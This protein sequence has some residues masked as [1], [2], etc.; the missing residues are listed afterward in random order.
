MQPNVSVQPVATKLDS[1]GTLF[2]PFGQALRTYC[3]GS[4]L[5]LVIVSVRHDGSVMRTEV[6]AQALQASAERVETVA[7]SMF[8]R[9]L[10]EM[11]ELKVQQHLQAHGNYPPEIARLMQQK[12]QEDLRRL[13]QIRGELVRLMAA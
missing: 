3:H 9:L 4:G 8:I 1:A 13:E 5:A 7:A 10:E 6:D 2:R 11:V 12:R